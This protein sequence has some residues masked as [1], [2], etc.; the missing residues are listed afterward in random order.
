MMRARHCVTPLIL[1]ATAIFLSVQTPG[2]ERAEKGMLESLSSAEWFTFGAPYGDV[3][4]TSGCLRLK[5][6]QGFDS[7]G[8]AGAIWRKAI[9]RP[10][11]GE[12]YVYVW[13]LR[14]N[15]ALRPASAY[16]ILSPDGEE[17]SALSERDYFGLMIGVS[18]SLS[19]YGSMI[20]KGATFGYHLLP[21][22]GDLDIRFV[23]TPAD[24]RVDLKSSDS[25]TWIRFPA[26]GNPWRDSERQTLYLRLESQG[27]LR[28]ETAS[29]YSIGG[30]EAGGQD[31][32][33]PR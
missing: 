7:G 14:N 18:P 1:A 26:V 5:T 17:L 15:S 29:D 20:R 11:S 3:R 27:D 25:N 4:L 23:I 19:L 31:L 12:L 2:K 8:W 30:V 10:S 13:R 16:L 24:Q 6:G 28:G 33:Q 22:P 32:S 9:R 21:Q